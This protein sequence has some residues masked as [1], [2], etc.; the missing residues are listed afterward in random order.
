M[1]AV[2]TDHPFP[3]LDISREILSS[4][5]IKMVVLQTEDADTIIANAKGTDAMLVGKAR[6]DENII[7]QLQQCKI[8]VRFGTGYDNIDLKAATSRGI[9]VANVPD[10]CMDEVSD[11][12]MGL[13]LAA[14]RQLM[15]GHNMAQN[16]K[17]RPMPYGMNT[18]YKMRD[19]VLGLFSYGRISKLV[20]KKAQ[21]FGLQCLAFDPFV[22]EESMSQTGV[23]KVDFKDLLAQSDFISLHSLL[24]EKTANAFDLD[25]FRAMKS[26]AWII[27]TARGGIIREADLVEALDEKLIAGAALDVLDDEPPGKG[28]PLLGR[29]NVIITPHMGW[30]SDKAPESMQR[31]GVEQAARVLTGA[32]P[33]NVVNP[34]VLG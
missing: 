7:G 25:A 27:N 9:P 12:A 34:E 4:K 5:G 11:H 2:I 30:M 3:S 19:R 20:A 32:K 1:K 29:D 14:G 17:W 21:A 8:I 6:I 16:G 28:N 15:V 18:I 31:K 23:Q 24:T 26:S 33:T 22:S 13:I 10:F